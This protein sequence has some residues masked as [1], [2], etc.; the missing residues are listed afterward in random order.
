MYGKV[1]CVPFTRGGY[2]DFWGFIKDDGRDLTNG[3]I[4]TIVHTTHETIMADLKKCLIQRKRDLL[5]DYYA[6][7]TRPAMKFFKSA[8]TTYR[9]SREAEEERN[10]KHTSL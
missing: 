6:K 4:R 9:A 5:A 2:L 1:I 10:A 7:D 3:A 8:L